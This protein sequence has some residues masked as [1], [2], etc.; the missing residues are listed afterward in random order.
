MRSNNAGFGAI[1]DRHV[2]HA[3]MAARDMGGPFQ[4]DFRLKN[5]AR[6]HRAR[7]DALASRAEERPWHQLIESLRLHHTA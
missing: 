3:E 1:S 6:T 2:R 5:R 4:P 7:A